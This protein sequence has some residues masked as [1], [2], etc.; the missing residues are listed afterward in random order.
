MAIEHLSIE[1]VRG[2]E[3]AVARQRFCPL[4]DLEFVFVFLGLVGRAVVE[5]E[6]SP[7]ATS[8]A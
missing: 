7:R 5:V 3:N 4:Q 8:A 1:H 6:K 2:A